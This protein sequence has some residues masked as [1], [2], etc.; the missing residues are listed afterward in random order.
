MVITDTDG[1]EVFDTDDRLFTVTDGPIRG[2]FTTPVRTITRT[3]TAYTPININTNH[4][5]TSINGSANTIRGA[6][7]ATS[8]SSEEV[9]NLGWFNASG[10]WVRVLFPRYPSLGGVSNAGLPTMQV[11]TFVASGGVLYLNEQSRIEPQPLVGSVT[12]STVTF[13]PITLNY[14]LFAG[15]WV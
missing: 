12:S 2:S 14:Y 1:T 11:L 5:I 7:Q 10:S 8:T 9:S 15:A 13:S 4:T 6:F 3:T